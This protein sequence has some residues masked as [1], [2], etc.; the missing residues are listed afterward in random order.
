MS[1]PT[2]VVYSCLTG[3]ILNLSTTSRWIKDCWA[4]V[5]RRTA[6]TYNDYSLTEHFTCAVIVGRATEQFLLLVVT[7]TA[8]ALFYVF[9]FSLSRIFGHAR[10]PC[11]SRAVQPVIVQGLQVM[12]CLC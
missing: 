12:L 4:A 11:V 7:V 10:A 9:G 1:K 6:T 3:S 2:N 5:S 8:L